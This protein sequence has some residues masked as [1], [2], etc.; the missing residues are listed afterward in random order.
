MRIFFKG[1]FGLAFLLEREPVKRKPLE[2][3]KFR[4]LCY[5]SA[6]AIVAAI[7]IVLIVSVATVMGR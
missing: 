5:L 7:I 3:D 4:Y 1:P 2:L 6:L